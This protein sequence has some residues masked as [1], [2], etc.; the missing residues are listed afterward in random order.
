MK[1]SAYLF[2]MEVDRQI[3]ELSSAD[4]LRHLNRGKLLQEE[5]LPIS[6]LA[7]HLKQPGLEIEVEAFENNGEA[8]GHIR[9]TGFREDEFNVQVTCDFTHEEALRKELLVSKGYTP[10]A[11]D[12]HRDKKSGQIVA[13]SAATDFDEHIFRVSQSVIKL[14]QKKV[15]KPYNENTVL[16]IA[17]DNVKLY[18]H[19][20]WRQLFDLLEKA[21]G[22]SGSRFKAIYLFNNATNEFQ[23]AA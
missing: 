11:G 7:L 16:I 3:E 17:F 4:D 19:H 8:D 20:Y 6:R 23:R 2:A 22:L 15:T 13:T 12:I 9:I 18:G 5:I 21:G 1:N 10:G 14:F